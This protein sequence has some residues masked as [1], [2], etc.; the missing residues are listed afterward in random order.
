MNRKLKG[1]SLAELLISLLVIS[2]VLSAAIPT[3]TK[4]SAQDR[5]QIWK[6]STDNNSTY[7]GLGANQSVLVG[8]A[9]TPMDTTDDAETPV[10]IQTMMTDDMGSSSSEIKFD[11]PR[12]TTD[13]DKLV[14]LKKSMHNTTTNMAN[15]HI[16]FYN[17][18]NRSTTSTDK[19]TYGGRIAVDKH[20]LAFGRAT[21]LHMN[22]IEAIT[23]EKNLSSDEPPFVGENT[24]V[25][26]FALM[27]TR[28]G[29]K[30]VAVGGK[31]LTLNRH[32]SQNTALG[33]LAA[34]RIGE[35]KRLETPI[36]FE[37]SINVDESIYEYPDNNTALGFYSLANNQ[38]GYGNV[39]IGASSLNNSKAGD[40]N[41]AIG[42]NAFRD[43]NTGYG[44]T[45]VGSNAC[46]FNYTGNYNICLGNAVVNKFT[47]NSTKNQ[48]IRKENFSL[49]IGST[50]TPTPNNNTY[51]VTY[52]KNIHYSAPL[53]MGHTQRVGNKTLTYSN[54]VEENKYGNYDKELI[55]NAK[56]VKFKPFDGG[57]ASAFVFKS[58]Y[59]DINNTANA[60]YDYDSKHIVTG[61][62]WF[63]LR[64]LVPP[65]STT[66]T[67]SK[68]MSFKAN[69]NSLDIGSFN[70]T[71]ISS[72][73]VEFVDLTFNN[74]LKFDMPDKSYAIDNDGN[75]VIRSKDNTKVGIVGTYPKDS[76]STKAYEILLNNRVNITRNAAH[77]INVDREGTQIIAM[78]TNANMPFEVNLSG[79]PEF[80]VH[81]GRVDFN[82]SNGVHFFSNGGADSTVSVYQSGLNAKDIFINGLSINGT[83]SVKSI[84][85]NLSYKV[86]LGTPSDARLKNIS[87]DNTAGLNEINKIEVKN[88][89]YKN[90]EKKEPHVGVIAQQLQKIFPNSVV[91]GEDGYLR[92]KTEEIFYAMV[93][94]IKELFAKV[95]DLTAKV[96]GLDKRITEL[97]AQNKML[98]EQN[99]AFEKRLEKLEKQA[100]K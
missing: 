21:L 52:N 85:Q 18:E 82:P 3:L 32:G 63:N 10:T 16:S 45:A 6:W 75:S 84:L 55:I 56:N 26:H 89:T 50:P 28:D 66:K 58:A 99:K 1:F 31:T 77:T 8:T 38:R 35:L 67:N 5:E 46:M 96:V 92:I 33:F 80:L 94:S 20:N 11:N 2:I 70:P 24:A 43:L 86:S 76:N 12:F 48:E 19:M 14:I 27:N 13:G 68:T 81:S 17:I 98:L 29:S 100:A 4:R 93:N 73:T 62:A 71:T 65:S 69:E 49:V 87:G 83:S 7:F 64:Y 91:K 78:D 90:D 23:K 37:N 74:V 95:Q 88:F 36:N 22:D 41:T 15:S 79:T 25:G 57:D 42:Y 61:E 53:I 9:A 59:G 44:N 30:N 34:N 39:A 54:E 72:G 60:G 40:N 47:L 51:N 97:E